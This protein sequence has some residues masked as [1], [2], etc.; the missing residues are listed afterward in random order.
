VNERY[1]RSFAFAFLEAMKRSKVVA[2][3][4]G[5]AAADG[6][7]DAR[8]VMEPLAIAVVRFAVSSA[9]AGRPADRARLRSNQW[10]AAAGVIGG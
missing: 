4:A 7:T 2:A 1:S 10:S 6:A 3:A 8:S 9:D 5:A